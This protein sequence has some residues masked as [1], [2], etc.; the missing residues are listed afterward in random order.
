MLVYGEAGGA[1]PGAYRGP[2]DRPAIAEVGRE[3][4]TRHGRPHARDDLHGVEIDSGPVAHHPPSGTQTDARLVVNSPVY[5]AA[6]RPAR[7]IRSLGEHSVYK[8]SPGD[9]NP[10]HA[11]RQF[12]AGS[13][14][15]P[16]PANVRG[17][18]G[19][20]IDVL[21]AGAGVIGLTTG[22]CLV[23]L[24][25]RTGIRTAAPPEANQRPRWPGP[26]GARSWP[27]RPRGAGTG[28]VPTWR[29]CGN[30]SR[31][32]ARGS[33]RSPDGSCPASRKSP[34]TGST[35]SMTCGFAAAT[36][37]RPASCPAGGTPRRWYACRSTSSTCGPV[38]RGRAGELT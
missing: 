34:R 7:R 15:L 27:A 19:S 28:P 21:V 35:S 18:D 14:G 32:R 13:G 37:C 24:G 26:S 8:S 6:A 25:L 3:N 33:G 9:R 16:S 38:S 31:S 17:M 20:D 30:S 23:E 4:G 22:I 10:W 5:P 1:G 2:R 11:I 12:R 36:T 29:R